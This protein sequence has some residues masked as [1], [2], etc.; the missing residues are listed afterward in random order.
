MTAREVAARMTARPLPDDTDGGEWHP[1]YSAAGCEAACDTCGMSQHGD[2]V[3]CYPC[4]GTMLILCLPCAV[5]DCE[6]AEAAY[7]AAHLED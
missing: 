5:A 4:A 2:C 1:A 6:R 3:V 7:H